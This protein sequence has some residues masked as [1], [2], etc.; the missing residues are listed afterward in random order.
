MRKGITVTVA[1]LLTLVSCTSIDKELNGDSLTQDNRFHRFH[2]TFEQKSPVTKV[3]ADEDLKLLWNA[4]DLLTVFNQN[5]YNSKFEFTGEDGDNAGDFDD[6]T[7]S[8]L[9]TSNSL[10]NIYAVYPYAKGNKINNGGNTITLTLPAEQQYKE[11]SFG[12]G[13]NTMVAV[14][15]NSFLAFKNVAGYLQLR[16]YG[17]NVKVS[18]IMIQGNNGEKIAGKANVSVGLGETPSVAMDATATDAIT[19]V[20]DPPVQ[21][22]TSA[23]DYTDFWFVIPPTTFTNGFKITVTDELGGTYEKTTTKSLTIVR[24][25]MEY[26]KA[27]LVT[28][29]YGFTVNK[30]LT[31]SSE[32]TTTL[33][34]QNNGGNAPLLYYSYDKTNWTRWDYSG[35]TFTTSSPLYICGDNPDGFSHNF[36]IWSNF[37]TTGSNF[38]VSGDIMSLL[39]KDDDLSSVSDFCF[40]YLFRDCTGLLSGPE[41]P[42][43]SLAN[44]CYSGMFWGCTNLT[45]APE[46]PA[47]T[48]AIHC[49]TYMFGHSGLTI[50]P[51]LPATTLAY[52]CYGSMFRNCTY[53]TNAPELP[54]TTLSDNCYSS[55]FYYCTSLATAPEL[56]ATTLAT[57]CYSNMF[58]GC[59]SLTIAPELPAETLANSCYSGMFNNCT[60]LTTAPELPATTLASSCYSFMFR[61]CS[62]LNYV[63]CLGIVNYS[64]TNNWLSGVAFDGTFIKAADVNWPVGASG[65]PEGWTIQNDDGSPVEPEEPTPEPISVSKYLTFTST[66][67]TN[68]CM[69]DNNGNNPLLYYSKDLTNWY[70]WDHST[71][72]FTSSSPLYICG[73]NSDGISHGGY[74]SSNQYSRFQSVGDNFGVSGDIMSLLDYDSDISTVPAEYCFYKLFYECWN[75]VSAPE[76]QAITLSDHCYDTLFGRTG[77]LTAPELPATTLACECYRAM[78]ISCDG[79]I[80]APVLPATTMVPYCYNLMFLGCSSLTS[81]PQLPATTMADACYYCMFQECTSLTTA[82]EL[83]ATTLAKECYYGMFCYCESLNYVKCLATDISADNCT[84]LWLDH[85]ASTGTFVKAAAI[86]WPAG[87]SGIPADWSVQN[88][89]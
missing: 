60:S 29:S 7:P 27:L 72:T 74:Y 10:D 63:K 31:F 81:A 44:H 80:T 40:Y 8:G 38:C 56:A 85:V 53:L 37:A 89:E 24:S 9:H 62:N 18:S 67:T 5:T 64:S 12:I 61:G 76:L 23:E 39:D 14:T 75:L 35:L 19:I 66:G 49:Y 15:D 73:D 77:L 71:L 6:V 17:N 59:S 79:L 25:Q 2:A 58:E 13:A 84:G 47:T 57:S 20:C 3:Y 36:S 88:A 55:M 34:L 22:G 1:I 26:M 69:E 65:I 87:V 51:E 21:I 70:E 83:P 32:G 41:L 52:S 43:T 30:Y 11:R 86:D 16:L 4:G 54:A 68:I 48:L 78:F 42:A 50:S 46:L 33:S 28:P 82:P 45:T